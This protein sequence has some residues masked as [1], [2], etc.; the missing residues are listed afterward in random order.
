MVSDE[1]KRQVG[2]RFL[3]PIRTV[4]LIEQYFNDAPHSKSS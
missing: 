1:E 4:R 2:K 3:F